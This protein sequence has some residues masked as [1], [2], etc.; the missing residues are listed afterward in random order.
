MDLLREMLE[1]EGCRV[2]L[3]TD[4][5]AAVD[6]VRNEAVD[7]AIVDLRMPEK[8]GLEALKEIKAVNATTE[9]LIMTAY[10]DIQSLNQILK[11]GA[12]DYIIKPFH[13][14]E[15]LHSV[16]NA[17]RKR[18]FSLETIRMRRDLEERIVQIQNEFEE[19]TRQL[20]ESQIKYRQIVDNSNDAI[21][22]AQD[23]M[24]KFANPRTLEITG[25]SL[26]EVLAMPFLSLIHPDDQSMVRERH[27]KRLKGEEV[28]TT[29]A[30]RVVRKDGSCCWV[31]INAIRTLWGDG[32]AT[33]NFVRDVSERKQAE[34]RLAYISTH[35]V[36]TGV[37]NRAWFE[38]ELERLQHSRRFPI[39]VV[40]AD[41]D[42]LKGI[43]DQFGHA[44]G[45]ELLQGAASVLVNSFR[46]EDMVARIGGDE[47]AVL[48][49][50]TDAMA[51]RDAVARIQENVRAYR[52]A[53]GG[54]S[55]G[56]S[57]GEAT[58]QRGSVLTDVFRD[59][60]GR[61]YKEKFSHSGREGL[62]IV[63]AHLDHEEIVSR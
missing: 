61:M 56:L 25:Y 52:M 33:L 46:A 29:Y 3:A 30:F 19:R 21:V 26:E 15:I 16:Q 47:F 31:E 27:L 20:R 45:D 17:M 38:E 9:V 39:S 11:G 44:K 50:G 8:D 40:V 42:N 28:P 57:I 51:V 7:V 49:P 6:I 13:K 63:N 53:S 59:A 18:D 10:A 34:E 5:R 54:P 43:N 23:G 55:L 41:V 2:S 12:F 48:L 58:G 4:G 14:V 1:Y 35:D 62:S 32:P 60:D 36:L 22:I 24:L 37:Y